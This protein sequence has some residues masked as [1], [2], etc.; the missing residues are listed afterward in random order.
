V[1]ADDAFAGAGDFLIEMGVP[2]DVIDVCGDADVW[3]RLLTE[4]VDD[5]VALAEGVDGAAA[6]GIHGVEWF[7][8]ELDAGGCGVVDECGDAVGDLFAVFGEGDFGFYQRWLC[9]R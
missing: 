2:P 1:E 3:C 7:D 9:S 5:V 4:L 8:G 6:V